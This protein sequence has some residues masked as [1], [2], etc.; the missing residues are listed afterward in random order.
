MPNIKS[1]ISLLELENMLL[2]GEMVSQAALKRHES[3]GVHYREDYPQEDAK[4]QAT[5]I[6]TNRAGSVVVEKKNVST[7]KK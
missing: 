7:A 5:L 2:V 1:L 6:S 3:R 4:W